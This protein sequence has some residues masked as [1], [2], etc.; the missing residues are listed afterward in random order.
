VKRRELITLLGGAAAWPLAARAQQLPK[1]PVIG[2]MGSGSAAA[3]SH[4]TA[5]FLQRLRELG[6]TEGRDVRIEYRWGEGRN[7]RFAEIAAELVR[8]KVDLILT[9]NT[10]PTLAAKQATSVIPIVFATA[11]DPVGTGI[12]ASLARPGGNI[13]GLSGQ[14]ADTVGKRVELL[15]ELIP[16]LRRLAILSD[17]D[18]PLTAL[19]IDE[20]QRAARAFAIETATFESR[21]AEDM[22]AAFEALHGRMQALYVSASPIFF[23]NRMR[24]NIFALTARLPTMY[25]V[26]EPVEIGGL[27]SYG[28]HWPSMWSRAADVVDKI[29]RGAKPADIPI[30]QPTKF[31]LV[32]NLVTAKALGVAVPPSLLARADDVI[33]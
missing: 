31:E 2:L 15:R 24:I 17:V 16:D 7:E 18:S 4:L 14:S 5:A 11:G 3:Q 23:V 20:V 13:T 22:A 19:E 8:L 28:A 30:E 25:T 26:R 32:V 12:V 29:L 10:P 21:R 6:W 27:I 33:E 9:H 1:V